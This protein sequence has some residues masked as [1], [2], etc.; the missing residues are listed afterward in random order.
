MPM[1]YKSDHY[2][3]FQFFNPHLKDEAPGLIK[4]LKWLSTRDPAPW[5]KSV[6]NKGVPKLDVPKQKSD[7]NVTFINHA[8][9]LIQ[10]QGIT[11]L[12]DPI[13][14]E[15]CSP[16]KW[17]GPKRVRQPGVEFDKLP[18]NKLKQALKEKNIS[19]QQFLV[20]NFGES[21]IIS[22][23]TTSGDAD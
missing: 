18:K 21:K 20:L 17:M 15:R 1:S 3:G 9:F 2:D 14:S 12:T 16:V 6:E 10:F 19:N 11:I 4:V 7:I 5:P 8:S 23:R 22:T 13:Y